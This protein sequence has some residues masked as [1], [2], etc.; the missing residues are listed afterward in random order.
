[1][2]PLRT[3]ILT[4]QIVN[5]GF[6]GEL[7]VGADVRAAGKQHR[8]GIDGIHTTTLLSLSLISLALP[9]ISLSLCATI[10]ATARLSGDHGR[11]FV[12]RKVQRRCLCLNTCSIIDEKAVVQR[13]KRGHAAT[14]TE[15]FAVQ[16]HR[17]AGATALLLLLLTLPL[18]LALP[19]TLLSLLFTLLLLLPLLL[20][21]TATTDHSTLYNDF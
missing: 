6:V 21:T 7:G 20:S 8:I 13:R 16:G 10:T 2:G 11:K 19:P 3:R 5:L 17:R 14:L 18:L 1:M 15:E 9:L 4:I 12:D